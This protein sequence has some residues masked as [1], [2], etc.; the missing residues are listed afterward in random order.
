MF[1]DERRYLVGVFLQLC[2]PRFEQVNLNSRP[3][4]AA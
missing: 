2:E 4:A 3:A 1:V